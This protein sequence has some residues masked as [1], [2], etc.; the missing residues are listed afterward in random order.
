[1]TPTRY[2]V[3]S[4]NAADNELSSLWVNHPAE[5][6]A[7][8][9]ASNQVDILL[10]HNAEQQGNPAPL[11]GVPNRRCVVR[12]PLRVYFVVSEPDRMVQIVSYRWAL[13]SP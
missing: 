11:P 3:T 6:A 9:L 7:I 1:M 13:S 8:S 4:T 5:K 12:Y 10:R 2:T